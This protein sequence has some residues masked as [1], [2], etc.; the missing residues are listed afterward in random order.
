M[1]IL[2]FAIILA[3]SARFYPANEDGCFRPKRKNFEVFTWS[4]GETFK[5]HKDCLK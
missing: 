1:L 5:N 4:Y 3:V 2:I